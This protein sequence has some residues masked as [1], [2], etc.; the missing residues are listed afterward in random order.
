[1]CS[2]KSANIKKNFVQKMKACTETAQEWRALPTR[3]NL[4][5]VLLVLRF[6]LAN[7]ARLI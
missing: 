4:K 1:M 6:S 5:P 2:T 3:K 7:Y